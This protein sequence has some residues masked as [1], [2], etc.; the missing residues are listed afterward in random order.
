MAISRI[1]SA[2]R[3][4]VLICTVTHV[5]QMKYRDGDRVGL[6]RHRHTGWAR[7]GT[8]VTTGA[9][10]Q[11]G[12][13]AHAWRGAAAVVRPAGAW[14]RDDIPTVV[15]V[16]DDPIQKRTPNVSSRENTTRMSP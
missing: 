7:R 13:G 15:E 14:R 8:G 10:V 1:I 3:A 6:K 9:A 5:G 4:R 2:C 11:A 16:N 12:G